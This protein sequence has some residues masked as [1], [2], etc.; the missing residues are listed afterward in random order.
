MGAKVSAVHG[1]KSEHFYD[2]GNAINEIWVGNVEIISRLPFGDSDQEQAG[3]PKGGWPK[4]PWHQFIIPLRKRGDYIMTE[5]FLGVRGPP[6]VDNWLPTHGYLGMYAGFDQSVALAVG[7]VFLIIGWNLFLC[8]VCKALRAIF[9]REAHN[10]MPEQLR[11]IMDSKYRR[12]L[13]L[14]VMKFLLEF[15]F[16]AAFVVLGIPGVATGRQGLNAGMMIIGDLTIVFV[17]ILLFKIGL[18]LYL[19]Y[20]TRPRTRIRDNEVG[21]TASSTRLPGSMSYE[22]FQAAMTAYGVDL[23]VLKNVAESMGPGDYGFVVLH[24][25]DSCMEVEPVLKS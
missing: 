25:G 21:K 5:S 12:S 22:D 2:Q 10:L 11:N 8:S 24:V 19:V 13:R 7:S 1:V 9:L 17:V 3:W 18:L 15:A 16:S 20:R 23:A 4:I 6:P 14:L